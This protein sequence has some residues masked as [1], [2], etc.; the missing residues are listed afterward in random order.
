MKLTTKQTIVI[1]NSGLS[2]SLLLCLLVIFGLILSSCSRENVH[3]SGRM[4]TEERAV[5]RFED[6]TLE[7]PLQVHLEQDQRVPVVIEAEDNVMRF[8]ETFVNGT[9]LHVKIRNNV[10]L[11]SFRPINVYVQNDE[12]RRII[13][14]GSGS[15]T[16][17]DT[18]TSTLFSYEIN[19]SADARLKLD[20]NEVELIVNGSGDMEVEGRAGDYRAEINGSGDI[21]A[22][23]LQ[24]ENAR[25][26]I[27]GSGEQRI[28]VL[29]LLD[30]RITGSGNIRYK[31]TP[32]TV[33][34]S[35]NGSGKVIK[36]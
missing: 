17:N 26:R 9:T 36:L 18:I 25:I 30:A 20:A 1:T 11:K 7:G 14:S 21:N 6:I 22:I 34:T 15:L 28:W 33:N 2:V 35:I 29:D 3:G 4:V 23:G 12:F 27:S 32:G 5:G 13:F 16:A 31:E 24:V 19:G 10:N 8:V